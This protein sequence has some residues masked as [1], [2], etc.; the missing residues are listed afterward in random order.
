MRP[1]VA[2]GQGMWHRLGRYDHR[3]SINHRFGP[4]E[5][6]VFSSNAESGQLS[7][8]RNTLF[9]G[10]RRRRTQLSDSPPIFLET[11]F[12]S[13]LPQRS[14]NHKSVRNKPV[15]GRRRSCAPPMPAVAQRKSCSGGCRLSA[16]PMSI[17]TAIPVFGRESA[18]SCASRTHGH[19]PSEGTFAGA[20]M[21]GS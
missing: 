6:T 7:R 1:I 5:M 11:G 14:S 9:L 18:L 12:G 3:V 15:P 16:S 4:H 8:H 21:L 10:I 17:V 13:W 19:R 2:N 20:L